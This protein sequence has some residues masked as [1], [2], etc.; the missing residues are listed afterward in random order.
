MPLPIAFERR[1]WALP[2]VVAL[3]VT[4][5]VTALSW[6]LPARFASTGVGFAFLG[7][8]Y[9]MVLRHD[10]AVVRRHGLSLGG[11]FER[12]VRLDPVRLA[13]SL[14][15]AV[16]I[17]LAL[18]VLI[19]PP[20]VVGYPLYWGKIVGRALVYQGQPLNLP[21]RFFEEVLGQIFVIALP[22]EA[23]FRG[24]LQTRLERAWPRGLRLFGA[25]IGPALVV[26]SLIFA[27]GHVATQPQ[28]PRLAVFFPSLLFGALRGATGGI[29]AS[30]A[31]HAM[32]NLMTGLLAINFGLTKG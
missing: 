9:L 12:D 5:V 14:A 32:C 15:I 11:L 10:D 1:P 22:E 25:T 20:F 13:R 19:F 17:A 30:V 6:F 16:G 2:L 4:I 18:S 29:G 24:F 7:A 3:A 31:F 8:T 23:F 27:L 26:T 28:L 21:P